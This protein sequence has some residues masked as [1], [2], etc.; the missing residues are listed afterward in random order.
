MFKEKQ[1]IFCHKPYGYIHNHDNIKLVQSQHQQGL[2]LNNKD[3][4]TI[5]NNYVIRRFNK[6]QM[7]NKMIEETSIPNM[8]CYVAQYLQN[9]KK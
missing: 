4:Q 3:R 1:F 7:S 2:K 8:A 6:G 5:D 9:R